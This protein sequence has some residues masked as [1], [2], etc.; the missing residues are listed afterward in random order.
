MEHMRNVY[1][2]STFYRLYGI[3]PQ[4]SVIKR[5][6]FCDKNCMLTLIENVSCGF[7]LKFITDI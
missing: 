2:S 1:T 4:G 3:F 5:E 7:M 6:P